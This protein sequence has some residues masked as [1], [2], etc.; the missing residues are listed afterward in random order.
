MAT[1]Y[2]QAATKQLAPAYATQINAAK[3]QI[4][5]I[6]QLYQTLM[7]GLTGFQQTENQNIL[8]GASGRGLLNSTIPVDAQTTLG[9]QVVAKQGEYGM[10]QGQQLGE[11]YNQIAG[12]NVNK[13]KD[14]AGLG[15]NMQQNA[16]QQTQFNYQKQQANRQYQLAK[17]AA[18]KGY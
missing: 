16:L 4:P 12:L 11:I 10:Q 18:Q 3:S 8:E 15:L 1:R 17:A 7:Q 2:V 6:Q 9:Q 13:A 14:I 5:A